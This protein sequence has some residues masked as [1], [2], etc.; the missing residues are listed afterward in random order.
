[1]ALIHVWPADLEALKDYKVPAAAFAAC[2]LVTLYLLRLG[3]RW[4][5]GAFSPSAPWPLGTMAKS[6]GAIVAALSLALGWSA[7]GGTILQSAKSRGGSAPGKPNIV[8]IVLD[9]V[10][11]DH[12]SSYGYSRPTT[13]HLDRLA[14]HGV[15]FENAVAPSPWTHPSHASIFTGLLPHQHGANLYTPLGKQPRT[16]AEILQSR[17]YET[18]SFFA[19]DFGASPWGLVQGFEILGDNRKYLPHNLWPTIAARVGCANMNP[20]DLCFRRRATHVNRDVAEWLRRRSNRPFFLFINYFDVHDPYLQP[21]PYGERFGRIQAD[22]VRRVSFGDGL[23]L[24][25]PLTAAE[26]ASL[27][28]GYDN[29]LAYLDDKVGALID[30]LAQSPEWENT[31][32]IVTSDHGEAFGLHDFYL[33]SRTLYYREALH[34]PLIVT[35]PGVPAGLRVS[36]IAPLRQLFATILDLALTDHLP[37]RSSSLRRFWTPGHQVDPLTDHAVSE[38][39]PFLPNFRPVMMSIMTGQWH[40]IRKSD[41]SRELYDWKSDP[42]EN[43]D[44]ANSPERAQTMKELER[45]LDDLIGRSAKPWREPEYLLA[46]DGPG[47]SFSS[48]AL[49][50]PGPESP[51]WKNPPPIG[52]SQ[53]FF[54]ADPESPQQPVIPDE[55]LLRS[56]PYR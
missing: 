28:A 5:G 23:P 9:T 26:Q 56:L 11:A 49:H 2:F 3:W 22:V 40:Y 32:L 27:V 35:G 47:S 14:Q 54:T 21:S 39:V 13:P 46:L 12:L 52:S 43:V 48:R 51:A 15:L 30:L 33:H 37:F 20:P 17:G 38:L 16:L 18:A 1:M 31:Y 44:L 19:N 4:I 10:R 41:N 7:L 45:Q 29:G 53:V 8:L 34:V 55:E 6:L 36:S 24:D 25:P 50:M 42:E